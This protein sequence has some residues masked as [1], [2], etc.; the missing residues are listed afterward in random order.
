MPLEYFCGKDAGS[1]LLYND[2]EGIV[3]VEYS[4]VGTEPGATMISIN[5]T[6]AAPYRIAN[7]ATFRTVFARFVD[8][9]TL[10]SLGIRPPELIGKMIGNLNS[11]SMAGSE[12]YESFDLNDGFIQLH[13]S[14]D[15]SNII[16][17]TRIFAD[18]A[19]KIK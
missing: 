5:Y 14:R 13:R 4:A 19:S 15:P 18:K 6:A 3:T 7:E 1:L 8:E 16:V 10:H 17:R 9:M 11:Y 12:A 2:G